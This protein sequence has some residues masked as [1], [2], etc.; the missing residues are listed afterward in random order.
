[1]LLLTMALVGT[2]SAAT[3]SSFYVKSV[4]PEVINVKLGE[5]FEVLCTT[6]DWYEVSLITFTPPTCA[7]SPVSPEF[8]SY[9]TL[10]NF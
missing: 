7:P 5:P 6:Y 1:M 4:Q 9:N 8:L 2:A 10:S 3:S